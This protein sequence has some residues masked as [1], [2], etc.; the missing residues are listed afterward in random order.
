MIEFGHIYSRISLGRTEFE[1]YQNILKCIGIF[2]IFTAKR[3]T[4]LIKE[5]RESWNG[6]NF[7][8]EIILNIIIPFR[9]YPRNVIDVNEVT[10]LHGAPCKSAITT[11]FSPDLNVAENIGYN[12]IGWDDGSY[13]RNQRRGAKMQIRCQNF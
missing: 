8:N 6:D 5:K 4:W 12:K 7:R 2:I 3:K 10:F 1:E 13:L 9:N 11:Q